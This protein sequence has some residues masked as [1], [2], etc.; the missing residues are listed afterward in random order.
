MSK[1]QTIEQEILQAT[2]EKPKGK[3]ESFNEYFQRLATATCDLQDPEYKK[4]SGGAQAWCAQAAEAL[5]EEPPNPEAIK[6]PAEYD[7]ENDPPS[8]EE[9][10]VE[11]EAAVEEET[12]PAK[13]KPVTKA[14]GA[15][16][17]A[18]ASLPGVA[19]APAAAK[20][21]PKTR[22][23]SVADTIRDIMCDN[24][25]VTKEAV[26]KELQKR[27]LSFD[28]ARLDQVY[29]FTARVLKI[30]EEKKKLK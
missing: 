28:P 12:P 10:T 14:K 9:A 24:P 30:L 16:P 29:S 18:Q 27:K 13:A 26:G 7:K 22:T 21:E 17:K 4:L 1:K 2:G 6:A 11:E 8:K 3:K 25:T 15:E 5:S 23:S 20:S 19:A